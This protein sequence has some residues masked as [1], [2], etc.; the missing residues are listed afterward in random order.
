[1]EQITSF[2]EER[3]VS[4]RHKKKRRYEKYWD[5]DDLVKEV[6]GFFA[7]KKNSSYSMTKLAKESNVPVYVLS[8]WRKKWR[9]DNSYTPGTSIGQHRR[10]FNSEEEK[11]V[12]DL[13]RE[14]Y[15]N[16]GIMVRRKHLKRILFSLWQQFDIENRSFRTPILFSNHFITSFCNRQNF[17]FRRTRKKKR[18]E[19]IESEVNQFHAELHEVF[20]QYPVHRILNMDETPWHFVFIRGEVLA[21]RG[22]E[23]VSAQLPDDYRKS[24]TAIATIGADGSKYPP[25]FL[26]QG[27][28]NKSIRQFDRMESNEN[29]YELW[30]SKG[31]NTDE[32]TMEQYFKLAVKWMENEPFALLLDRYSSHIIEKIQ[33]IAAQHNIKLVYIPTS[34]TEKFQP[35]DR[36]VFGALKSIGA[37]YFDDH[38]FET[39]TPYTKSEA[40]D[41]FIR[42]WNQLSIDLILEAWEIEGFVKPNEE[43]NAEYDED[44]EEFNPFTDD[45]SSEFDDGNDDQ[46]DKEEFYIIEKEPISDEEH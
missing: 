11:I 27:M 36:R 8:R 19:I 37:S 28:T 3:Y 10:Y 22:S 12:A 14:Q 7:K 2:E 4:Y 41:I 26:A 15:I 18:S 13:I 29:S 30:Y 24:F 46:E 5:D 16:P 33:T 35:L 1:M 38:A 25:L 42:L 6:F 44:N 32:N 20:S 9:E 31:G 23:E 17:S 43:D 34:A 40:A 39:Q 21:E 45:D